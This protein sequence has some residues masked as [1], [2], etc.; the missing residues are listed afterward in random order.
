M[1][2]DFNKSTTNQRQ[3][4]DWLAFITGYF[5]ASKDT[6]KKV[7]RQTTEGE[8]TAANYISHKGLVSRRYKTTV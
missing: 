4:M 3:K 2:N 8:K 5:Y 7:K 6:V 1:S